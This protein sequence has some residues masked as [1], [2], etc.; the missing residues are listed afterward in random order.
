MNKLVCNILGAPASGK[1][2][3]ATSLFSQLKRKAINVGLVVEYATLAVM[4]QN[5][6]ALEDQ[7]YVW[8]T[9]QHHIFC[10]ST[11]YDVVVT[12]SPI[13]LGHIYNV[14]ASS[15]LQTVIL[16]THHQYENLNIFVELDTT[17]PYNM[18]GRIHSLTE[19]MVINQQIIDL[20]TQHG[21]PFLR[22][23]EYS[24]DEI[25]SLILSVVEDN[26]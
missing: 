4:E 1:T 13:L 6:R 22:Y 21:I 15:A 5:Q 3:I 12:D 24:D 7:L 25:V 11:H 23:H 26:E 18:T 17:R 20:L 8:S 10:A 2:T 19:A 14:E 16:E 9:Q